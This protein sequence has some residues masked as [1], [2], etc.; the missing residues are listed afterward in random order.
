M[1]DSLNL[2]LLTA[3]FHRVG[4]DGRPD[5][6]ALL[7]IG[8]SERTPVLRQLTRTEVGRLIEDLRVLHVQMK[9]GESLG[10]WFGTVPAKCD[11]TGKPITDSFVDGATRGGG[12]WGIMHPDAHATHGMGLGPGRGQRYIK[13]DG[14]W[15]K[16]EG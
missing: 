16:A 12:T 8:D 1:L 11:L 9:P 10:R 5:G 2:D 4:D 3:R 14:A 15:Y 7:F 13:R 6:E